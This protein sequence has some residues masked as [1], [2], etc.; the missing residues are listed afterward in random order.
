VGEAA[1]P[2]RI[3]V[4]GLRVKR[5][6]IVARVQ[7]DP[8]HAYSTPELA[9]QLVQAHPDLPQHA[10]VNPMGDRFG[11]VLAGTSLPHV[12]EH[13]VIDLQTQ[14]YAR[15]DPNQVFTGITRWVQRERGLAEVAVSYRDDL[16]A[17]RAFRDAAALLN[18]LR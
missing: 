8:A 10:C 4:A 5:D 13:L 14:A 2:P 7:V 3:Q 16:V 17:L 1:Q 9:Q 18:R 15:R 6:R 11:A 12:L